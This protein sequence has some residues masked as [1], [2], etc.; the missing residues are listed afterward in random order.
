M[1]LSSTPSVH[2]CLENI[3]LSMPDLSLIH[4]YK[5]QAAAESIRLQ[6]VFDLRTF[7]LDHS[8]ATIIAT[9]MFDIAI[10]QWRPLHEHEYT[11]VSPCLLKTYPFIENLNSRA[12]Q[13]YMTLLY[14]R[15]IYRWKALETNFSME[16]YPPDFDQWAP[17][18]KP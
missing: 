18:N 6:R 15:I 1:F 9:K 4:L 3:I 11:F 2:P 12:F 13:R 10:S 8:C 14:R 7:K 17:L 5:F 16:S